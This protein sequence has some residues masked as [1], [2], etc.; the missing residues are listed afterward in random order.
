MHKHQPRQ[1]PKLPNRIIRTHDRLPA[2]LARNPHPDIRLLNHR[3]I[4]RPIPNRQR[5]DL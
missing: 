5:H 1:E 4:V 2:L 3:H